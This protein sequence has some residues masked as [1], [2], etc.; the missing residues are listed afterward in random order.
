MRRIINYH[1]E[2]R[3]AKRHAGVVAYDARAV[4]HPQI[5]AH[6]RTTAV[7]PESPP[8]DSRIQNPNWLP[9]RIETEH[10]FEENGIFAVP[11]GRKG[12]IRMTL[13]LGVRDSARQYKRNV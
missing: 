13:Y 1:V 11:N 3:L 12:T 2:T 7:L 4:P 5:H 6:D 8:T 9:L 10:L